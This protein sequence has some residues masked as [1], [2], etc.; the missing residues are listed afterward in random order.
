[1]GVRGTSLVLIQ[2][3]VFKP[4]GKMQTGQWLKLLNT[5]LVTRFLGFYVQSSGNSLQVKTLMKRTKT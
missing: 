3:S 4:Y 5:C 1:M 2:V